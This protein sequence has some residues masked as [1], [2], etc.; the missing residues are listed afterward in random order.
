MTPILDLSV[1][2]LRSGLEIER[3]DP[4]VP[5]AN[6]DLGATV[7][8]VRSRRERQYR[9]VS[10]VGC[11]LAFGRRVEYGDASRFGD[12]DDLPGTVT[13]YVVEDRRANGCV[14]GGRDRRRPLRVARG[15]IEQRER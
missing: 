4:A 8:E 14:A 10:L 7:A 11:Q 2:S 9:H 1:G 12:S 6:Q 13:V 3:D 5:V 15:G